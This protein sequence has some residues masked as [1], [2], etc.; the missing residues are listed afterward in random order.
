MLMNSALY[1]AGSS[2]IAKMNNVIQFKCMG[3]HIFQYLMMRE[4]FKMKTT[5]VV[6]KRVTWNYNNLP[7]VKCWSSGLTKW[8]PPT[9]TS[10]STVSCIEFRLKKQNLYRPLRKAI[11]SNL[12]SIFCLELCTWWPAGASTCTEILLKF[13]T[14]TRKSSLLNLIWCSSSFQFILSS[15]GLYNCFMQQELPTIQTYCMFWKHNTFRTYTS[16]LNQHLI[17]DPMGTLQFSASR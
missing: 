3:M 17:S 12:S 16:G 13:K 7:S 8:C 6:K 5:H 10:K 1:E 2:I 14:Q 9:S 15:Q 4:I 11:K